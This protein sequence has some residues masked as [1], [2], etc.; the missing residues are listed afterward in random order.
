MKGKTLLL[1]GLMAVAAMMPAG[2]ASAAEWWESTSV[3]GR[4]Y[5]DFTN[6]DAK[7]HTWGGSSYTTTDSTNNGFSFDI[8]RFYVGIDHKFNDVFSANVTTDF[9]YDGGLGVSQVYIKKAYLDINLCPELDIRFGST[10]LPWI[11]FV[12]G[13]YGYR[14]VENT[15]TDRTHFGTSADWGAHIKGKLADGLIEYAVSV[16]NGAG[17]KKIVRTDSVDV[18]GRVNLNYMGFIL[19]VGGYSGKLGVQHGTAT[20]HTANRFNALAAYKADNIRVG[21]EY[22]Q[23]NDWNC[24]K[25]SSGCSD[26]DTGY[27]AFASYQFDPE[28]GVFGR[29]DWVSSKTNTGP[30]TKVKDNYY[31]F[32]VAYTPYKMVDFALVY[33]H[34]KSEVD[35]LHGNYADSDEVGIWGRLRW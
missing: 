21:F 27:S 31:N 13:V 26:K 5:Y 6:L 3:N 34:D 2:S 4:M 32:G 20:S 24:V 19:A 29:Y 10:D 7:M 15:L 28:W 18:E 16:V 17:Y 30:T 35:A 14:Y 9:T 23:S 25:T 12:E 11:P 1:A 33:K 22:F 8:K